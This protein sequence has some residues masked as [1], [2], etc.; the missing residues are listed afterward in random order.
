ML[1]SG[2]HIRIGAFEFM[3]EA[4]EPD[5][6]ND[7]YESL[8][9][10][11]SSIDGS[12]GKKTAN[13]RFVYW[14]FDDWSGGE[15]VKFFDVADPTTYWF[16]NVNPR[17]PGALTS[18]PTRT[19]TTG[20]TTTTAT[21]TRI[22]LVSAAGTL[23]LLANRQAFYS[24]NG[25]SW[26]A[27]ANNALGAASD[28]MTAACSSGDEIWYS[29]DNSTT[30]KV[31][32]LTTGADETTAVSDVTGPH[33]LGMAEREGFIYGWTGK[34]LLRY[35]SKATLPITQTDKHK[36]HKA[37]LDAPAGTYYGG[38]VAMDS[39][40]AY[41]ITY[42]GDSQVYFFQ[43]GRGFPVWHF[44]GKTVKAI[45]YNQGVLGAI[46]QQGNKCVLYGM[47]VQ[48]RQT[49]RL[50]DIG[51]PVAATTAVALAPG[52]DDTFLI[53]LNDGTTNFIY[54]YSLSMDSVSQL[55]ELT[56]AAQGT[57]DAVA[58]YDSRRLVAY[59]A[60]TTVK[61]D[62]WAT[63]DATP[64]GAWTWVSGAHDMSYPMDQKVL[65]G[66]HVVNDQ[67]IAAG[68]G[69]VYYQDDEDGIWTSAGTWAAGSK[70]TY[71]DVSASTVKY[72]NL[73]VRVVG[74]SGARLLAL[75]VRNFMNTSERMWRIKLK[76]KAESGGDR[77]SNRNKPASVLRSYLHT[78]LSDQ[79]AVTFLNG[80]R[81]E[82]KGGDNDGY[83]THTVVVDSVDDRIDTDAE[84]VATVILRQVAP[85]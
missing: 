81:Y 59:F 13:P 45:A 77:P 25:T 34:N 2:A 1:P 27:H 83:S 75:A 41:F 60:S 66:F 22:I 61:A 47:N 38:C 26:T 17:I 15:N 30:R 20:L 11:G 31:F 62:S 73:R 29:S 4:T 21:P 37:H 19:A 55:D 5:H 56:I 53:V 78:L 9:E 85:V 49:F 48:T 10:A 43:K 7:F 12:P 14:R 36:V 33:F 35:N 23:W 58:F 67:S 65:L 84:G 64:A 76:I 44:E 72:R 50:A 51:R 52:P 74:A 80:F 8:Y 42:P 79:N 46:A 16:G 40:I 69:T 63:D 57:A 39:G 3:V 54:S 71:I 82:K 32:K 24:T 6:F 68:N 28:M 70:H 18:P